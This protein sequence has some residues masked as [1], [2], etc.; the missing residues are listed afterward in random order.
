MSSAIESKLSDDHKSKKRTRSYRKF[1]VKAAPWLAGAGIAAG[2]VAVS[3]NCTVPQQGRCSSC[4]SC[5]VAVG[6]L[7]A[8]ALIKNR[9]GGEFYEER[10]S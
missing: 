5:I 8:W 4:G 10:P 3:T 6:S 7:V 2:H 9:Q 1:L